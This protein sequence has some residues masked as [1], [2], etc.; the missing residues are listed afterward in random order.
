[1]FKTYTPLP[2]QL[3]CSAWFDAADLRTITSSS[4]NVSKWQDKSGNGYNVTQATTAQMPATGS[5]T[6]NGLNVLSFLSSNVSN[7]A[8]ANTPFPNLSLTNSAAHV[9][10]VGRTHTAS[11]SNLP[12]FMDTDTNRF[13]IAQATSSHTYYFQGRFGTNTV[14][15]YSTF[16]PDTPFVFDVYYRQSAAQGGIIVNNGT[17]TVLGTPTYTGAPGATGSLTL[18]DPSQGIYGWIGECIIFAKDLSTSQITQVFN[19]L[20]L[21]WGL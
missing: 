7:L 3:G 17:P 8:F 4:G 10:M 6:Q 12:F 21:K 9:F 18:G 15:I 11:P 20:N 14:Q 5:E 19:Y 1:M 2:I 13:Q 16:V